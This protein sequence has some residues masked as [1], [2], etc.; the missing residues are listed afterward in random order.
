[1][2]FVLEN[3]L[4]KWFYKFWHGVFGCGC[5]LVGFAL[6]MG[7]A[8]P[9][10]D[11][12]SDLSCAQ[13]VAGF[14]F[15]LAL[16]SYVVRAMSGVFEIHFPLDQDRVVMVRKGRVQM[17]ALALSGDYNRYAFEG[18]LTAPGGLRVKVKG[19]KQKFYVV[20]FVTE[21]SSY[22]FNCE[23]GMSLDELYRICDMIKDSE[24]DKAGSD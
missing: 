24:K 14:G 1:M 19:D 5:A 16:H 7:M 3:N 6:L 15:P 11:C 23:P 21:R 2:D 18:E 10:T 20:A 17:D 22:A 12:G 8:N 9:W 13:R 4:F